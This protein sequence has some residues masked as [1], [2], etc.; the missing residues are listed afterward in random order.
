MEPYMENVGLAY[1]ITPVR[2]PDFDRTGRPRVN[3]D[4]MYDNMMNQ[5]AYG[6]MNQPGIYIDENLMRMCRTHRMMFAELAAALLEEGD[7]T[8]CVAVLDKSEAELPGY[9]IPYD[10]TSATMA[11]YY[12]ECGEKE[13][14]AAI[15]HEVAK[16]CSEYLIWGASLN[17]SRRTSMQRVLQQNGAILG[18]VLQQCERQG[19]NDIVDEFSPVY[20]QYV[21]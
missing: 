8:R 19:L 6:N 18:F 17:K 13:K 20:M 1:Q 21:R 5:F 15:L 4:K 7:R 9:N 3:V 12:L 10:Y 16:N 14:G 2:T 11:C